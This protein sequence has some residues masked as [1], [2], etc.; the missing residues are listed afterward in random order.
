MRQFMWPGTRY[1]PTWALGNE[2]MTGSDGYG[3]RE[4]VLASAKY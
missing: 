1:Q 2:P 4:R 3:V